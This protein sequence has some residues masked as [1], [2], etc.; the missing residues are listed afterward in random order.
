MI[1]FEL[2]LNMSFQAYFKMYI[3]IYGNH[4]NVSRDSNI[5]I[6][7]NILNY[8]NPAKLKIYKLLILTSI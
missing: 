6:F 2:T 1:E 7:I 4:D 3:C 8:L 5:W